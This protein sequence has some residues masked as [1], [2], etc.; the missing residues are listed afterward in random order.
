MTRSELFS[1]LPDTRTQ[2]LDLL[3]AFKAANLVWHLDD[4]PIYSV[5]HEDNRLFTESEAQFLDTLIDRL[6]SL[7]ADYPGNENKPIN[8]GAWYA[9]ELVN[10]G[11]MADKE[12]RPV[13]RDDEAQRII[14]LLPP[15]FQATYEYPGYIRVDIDEGEC[16]AIGTANG[17]WGYNVC[18]ANGAA[19]EPDFGQTASTLPLSALPHQVAAYIVRAVEHHTARN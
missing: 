1:K 2:A 10:W 15:S 5:D 4:N 13:S 11:D 7:F 12:P 19:W 18:D 14:A 8:G 6:N 17:E 16:L 3:L 9:A